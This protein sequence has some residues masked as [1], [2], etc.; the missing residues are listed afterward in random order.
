MVT[1]S[2]MRTSFSMNA[3]S[4]MLQATPITAPGK[5]WANAQMRV[6]APTEELST[7]AVSCLKKFRSA[8]PG[9]LRE[10]LERANDGGYFTVF[11]FSITGQRQDFTRGLFGGRQWRGGP[12]MRSTRRPLEVIRHGGVDARPEP[13]VFTGA[14]PR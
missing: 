2:P 1:R 9:L 11:E 12:R 14:P 13:A 6:P 7:M 8:N 5:M 4:Q 10:G 3:W